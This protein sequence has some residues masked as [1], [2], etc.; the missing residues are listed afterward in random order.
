MEMFWTSHRRK[1]EQGRVKIQR[2][3]RHRWGEAQVRK[4]TNSPN[5]RER[6]KLHEERRSLNNI[7]SFPL[8]F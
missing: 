1:E 6:P 3:K 8:K 5:T 7:Y 4:Q 2:Q